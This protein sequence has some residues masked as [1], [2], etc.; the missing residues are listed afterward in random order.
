[1]ATANSVGAY[2]S[3]LS[4]ITTDGVKRT[5]P[6]RLPD[7][8]V[9]DLEV[10][11]ATPEPMALGGVGDAAVGWCSLVEYRL[12][13]LCGVGGWEPLPAAVFLPVLRRFIDRDPAFARG[14]TERASAMADAL[15]AAGFAMTFAGE[16]A[17]ASGLEHVT[18]HMLDMRAHHA[19]RPIGNHGEQCGIATL[20][21]LLAYEHLFT[22]VEPEALRPRPID[23]KQARRETLDVFAESDPTGKAGAEC[24][25]DLAAKCEEWTAASP[26]L[27]ALVDNW[28]SVVAELQV[29]L[30][31]PRQY[32]EALR[33][34]GHPLR[35]SE[36]DERITDAEVRW[37]F[38]NARLMR[39]RV[40]VADLLG[41]AGLWD[42]LVDALL[43]RAESLALELGP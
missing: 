36:I 43:A 29:L 4:V 16:S 20:L 17:P 32:A 6:S 23:L 35:F 22:Q 12:A 1:V 13:H 25:S 40:F 10:L 14:G 26:A 37:A 3:E 24:W 11:A 7:V 21:V 8:L 9:Q 2:T 39:R 33:A 31:T 41:F 28:E 18:S 15:D 30:P 27:D 5:R 38:R 19:G 34:A 42:D